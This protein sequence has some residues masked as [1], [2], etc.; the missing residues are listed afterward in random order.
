VGAT[1]GSHGQ[2]AKPSRGWRLSA[3]PPPV[4]LALGVRTHYST[5]MTSSDRALVL[6]TLPGAI[7]NELVLPNRLEPLSVRVKQVI[8]GERPPEDLRE[9]REVLLELARRKSGKLPAELLV[10]QA[11]SVTVDTDWPSRRAALEALLRRLGFADRDDLAIVSRPDGVLGCYTLGGHKS[12]SESARKKRTVRPYCTELHSLEPLRGSCDCPDFLHGSLGLCKHLL[13]VLEDV[14]TSP[15]KRTAAVNQGQYLADAPFV[16]RWD[17]VRPWTGQGDRLTGLCIERRAAS[18]A[19]ARRRATRGAAF[20]RRMGA[21]FVDGHADAA[22]LADLARRVELLDALRAACTSGELEAESAAV[23]V[24]GAELEIAERRLRARNEAASILS[25]TRSIKRK[26]YPYQREGVRRFLDER[27]LLLADDM[28][29]GK[30]TQA[31]AACHAL[32]CSGAVKRGLVIVPAPLKSQWIREWQATTAKVPIA[33]VEGRAEER[34][35][36]LRS[37]KHGFLVMNYEQLLRDLES[38]HQFAPGVVVLDEAQRIKN[39]ATKSSAYVMTLRPEWRLV[40]TGTPMENRLEELATLLD[41]VDDVALTPKW[42]LTPWYTAWTSDGEHGRAGARHLDT[43][44]QRLAPSTLRRVRREVLSQLPPRTDVRLPVE[45]TGPQRDEHDAL[46]VPIAQLLQTGRRRPLRPPE[47]LKLMQLLTQQRIISNGMAQYEFDDVWPAYSRMRADD[48]LLGATCSPK[49]GAFRQ[50]FE[51]LVLDQ[52]RK[53]VVFSQWRKMLSLAEWAV[54][55][56]LEDY[57]LRSVFFSGSESQ[58][59]RTQNVV[60]FHDDPSVRLMFLTDAGGVGLNLQR[61]ANACI[62]LELPWNPAVLEQRIGRIYRLG[63]ESPIDVIN[64]VTEYGIEARIAGLVGNK[65]A[66]FS[67]LF[68]GTTDEVRYEKPAGFLSEVERL[69][70]P[71]VVPDLSSLSE[72]GAPDALAEPDEADP[73]A[74]SEADAGDAATMSVAPEATGPTDDVR[75]DSPAAA[76]PAPDRHEQ[77]STPKAPS[78]ESAPPASP[79]VSSLF[80]RVTVTRTPEGGLR[81][82]AAPEAAEELASLLQRL[83]GL[84]R[85][86]ASS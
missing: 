17:P 14:V 13:V 57:G 46:V 7:T 8:R 47:F 16:L 35:R 50:L 44:R 21:R 60:E 25:Y 26:L 11:L 43:L 78:M 18:E 27:R 79:H 82:D 77:E 71:A 10:E 80:D 52:D 64:L 32:Y 40:L 51:E 29:L 6:A 45:M 23:A 12:P 15:R 62:N 37:T 69:I 36:L 84:L 1:L 28:G 22:T 63:Q 66:L 55:D 73:D 61:A 67:G 30:T 20:E 49:L 83:A 68:D 74:R 53:V 41:W 86:G 2:A 5:D 42:R 75:E 34:A 70:E 54:R 3:R 33:E 4:T 76:E 9:T 38:V 24:V 59:Q 65:K 85:G 48:T 56:R 31:I 72:S 19:N 81:L 58:K 39:W